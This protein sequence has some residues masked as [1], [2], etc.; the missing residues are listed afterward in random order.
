MG[1]RTTLGCTMAEHP[2]VRIELDGV[3]AE[4]DE[5]L[6]DLILDLWRLGLWTVNSCQDNF[7]KVWIEFVGG[8]EAEAFASMVAGEFVFDAEALYSR[9]LGWGAA[10][11][12]ES[13]W[14]F[15]IAPDDRNVKWEGP[16]PDQTPRVVGPPHIVF[17]ASVR[18]P[19]TDLPE[20]KHRIRVWTARDV[21]APED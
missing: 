1:E 7:G 5:Q 12:P 11:D 16:H 9:V 14:Q 8:G 20:V 6:A 15:G 13:V 3:F 2:Q 17:T 10:E 21:P 19:P 4:V 18:F